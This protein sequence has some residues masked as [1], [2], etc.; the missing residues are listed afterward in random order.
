MLR[1]SDVVPLI[2]W[3]S[4][5]ALLFSFISSDLFE[6]HLFALTFLTVMFL[7]TLSFIT[8]CSA[9]KPVKTNKNNCLK[10]KALVLCFFF[11]SNA[12]APC[13]SYFC[14]LFPLKWIDTKTSAVYLWISIL[15]KVVGHLLKMEI[16]IV[17]LQDPNKI[18]IL[19]INSLDSRVRDS[20]CKSQ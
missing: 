11:K 10:K 18:F 14:L 6:L 3:S 8:P 20:L 9:M 13:Q 7:M 12:W 15:I 5:S 2:A 17:I 19:D 1:L 16:H 4:H